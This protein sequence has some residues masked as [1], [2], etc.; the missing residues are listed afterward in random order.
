M[1]QHSDL[2][3]IPWYK[4]CPF[5]FRFIQ[6]F[7][8]WLIE[9]G[10]ISIPNNRHRTSNNFPFGVMLGNLSIIFY[11]PIKCKTVNTSTNQTTALGMYLVFIPKDL[12]GSL[13]IARLKI[14][15]LMWPHTRCCLDDSVS[16]KKKY[17]KKIQQTSN[18]N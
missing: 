18:Y 2:H 3:V 7:N 8:C 5:A 14:W 10:T 1:V 15:T 13:L 4:P 12:V 17:G 9:Y 6:S 11:R 16:P